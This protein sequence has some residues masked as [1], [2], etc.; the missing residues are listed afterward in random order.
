MN[1]TTLSKLATSW[2]HNLVMCLPKIYTIHNLA[3][4][5]VN[6]IV[7]LVGRSQFEYMFR[8]PLTSTLTQ[9]GETFPIV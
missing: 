9:N 5:E 4:I 1:C 8:N 7:T 2:G 3:L 6:E